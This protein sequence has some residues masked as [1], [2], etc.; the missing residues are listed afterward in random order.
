MHGNQ[1]AVCKVLS[2]SVEWHL[3]NERIF[4]PHCVLEK[5]D[6]NHRIAMYYAVKNYLKAQIKQRILIRARA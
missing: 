1:L 6:C 3:V 2:V 5:N 4:L